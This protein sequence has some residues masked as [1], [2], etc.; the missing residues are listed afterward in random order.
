M[1]AIVPVHVKLE[2]DNLDEAEAEIVKELTD[3]LRRKTTATEQVERILA[4]LKVNIIAVKRGGSI[5][6]YTGCCKKEELDHLC[7]VVENVEAQKTL[8]EL[9]VSC[10]PKQTIRVCGVKVSEA[11]LEKAKKT[12]DRKS[13]T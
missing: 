5:V 11:D 12:F 10:V 2:S 9:F 8:E 3:I 6:L 1:T 4:K 7:Q 13:I